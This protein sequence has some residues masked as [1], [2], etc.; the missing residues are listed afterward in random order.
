GEQLIKILDGGI[1]DGR[2]FCDPRIRNK[3]VEALADDAAGQFCQLVW[4][5]SRR[6]IARYRLGSASGFAYLGDDAVGF[7][8]PATVVHENLGACRS[9]RERVG[10]SHAA[11]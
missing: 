8:D 4:P 1:L 5:I 7:F 3:N 10:A 11:R 2:G 6:Q 9:E